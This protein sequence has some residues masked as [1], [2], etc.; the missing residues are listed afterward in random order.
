MKD[1]DSKKVNFLSSKF[2]ILWIVFNAKSLWNCCPS[3]EYCP[4]VKVT[5]GVSNRAQQ[6]SVTL[7]KANIFHDNLPVT[8]ARQSASAILDCEAYG[9]PKPSVMW[10][11]SGRD[12]SDA[13]KYLQL[14]N[15]SLEIKHVTQ[16]DA[17]K[18]E[19]TASNRLGR[20]TV[21]RRLKVK[22]TWV[23]LLLVSVQS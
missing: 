4:I 5:N 22:S 23:L 9:Y 1:N 16:K 10:Y 20:K 3:L 14:A 13:T 17:G 2:S 15:G 21:V 19:C 7:V 11:S 6:L 18:Y 8:L 12:L